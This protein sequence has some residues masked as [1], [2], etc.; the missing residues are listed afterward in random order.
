MQTVKLAGR[1]RVKLTS[2]SAHARRR[3]WYTLPYTAMPAV[4][5]AGGEGTE[6]DEKMVGTH[7]HTQPCRQSGRQAGIGVKLTNTPAHVGRR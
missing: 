5:Q 3:W 7:S 2:K 4:R 6:T 1:G